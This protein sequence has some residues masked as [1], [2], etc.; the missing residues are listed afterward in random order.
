MQGEFLCE[1]GARLLRTN[2]VVPESLP[3][4]L[5]GKADVDC[6]LEVNNSVVSMR[7]LP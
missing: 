6:E 3:L 5:S 7:S 2:D 4:V 1:F